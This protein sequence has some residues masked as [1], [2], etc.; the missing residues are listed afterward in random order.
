MSQSV[1]I[2]TQIVIQLPNDLQPPQWG[3]PVLVAGLH[4]VLGDKQTPIFHP[5]HVLRPVGA[6]DIDDA[7]LQSINSQLAKLGLAMVR[8]EV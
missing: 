8:T 3:A 7:I 4:V 5:A 6:S 2:T 1:F